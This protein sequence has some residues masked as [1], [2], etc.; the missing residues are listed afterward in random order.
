MLWELDE[1]LGEQTAAV[2]QN[3][4]LQLSVHVRLQEFQYDGVSYSTDPNLCG[5]P[6][7]WG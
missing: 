7:H 6:A 1:L 3:V 4:A 5:L 2:A